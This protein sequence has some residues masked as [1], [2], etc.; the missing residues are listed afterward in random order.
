MGRDD[1]TGDQASGRR[2]RPVEGSRFGTRRCM[3]SLDFPRDG[4]MWVT[5]NEA[6]RRTT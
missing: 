1:L 3:P 5:Q 2:T 4:V 6:L